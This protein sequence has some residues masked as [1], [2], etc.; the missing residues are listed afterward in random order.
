V[1]AGRA[2]GDGAGLMTTSP[3]RRPTC[4]IDPGRAQSQAAS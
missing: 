4:R 2:I 1:D 3:T